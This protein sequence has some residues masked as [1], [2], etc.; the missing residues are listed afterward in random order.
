MDLNFFL[1]SLEYPL[2]EFLLY[3][4]LTVVIA[5]ILVKF[6]SF[7]INKAAEKFEIEMTLNYLLKDLMKYSIYIIAFVVI[8]D[9]AGI[10][11]SALIVSLGIVGITI[12]FAARDVISSFVSGMFLLADKTVKVG[13][14]IEVGDIK[15]KVKK[16]GFRTTTLIT[17]DNLIVTVP[18]AVL[19]K[20]PYINYTFL[21][22]HRIDLEVVIPF[23]VDINKFKD[24]FIQRVSN[25][26][27]VV[28]NSPPSV[29]VKEMIDSGIRLKISAWSKDYSQIENCRLKLADEV[30]KLINEIGE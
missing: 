21:D 5:L 13:E 19:A 27:W 14:V 7:L 8:L 11:I 10:D 12:G 29:L 23:N 26:E 25:L 4:V 15:G 3:S 20:N 1:Q 16:L 18:N 2:I 17:P 22:E 9:M 30:R 24:I 28:P 6:F